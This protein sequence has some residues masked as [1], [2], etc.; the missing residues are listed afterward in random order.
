MQTLISDKAFALLSVIAL[1]TA[2]A[3]HVG[4]EPQPTY[5]T[6]DLPVM[7]SSERMELTE[8]TVADV[9]VRLNKRGHGLVVDGRYGTNTND[10]LEMEIAKC[11]NSHMK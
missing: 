7:H 10:A 4:C 11:S 5:Q 6:Y 2:I 9:Q 3:L 8:G 1:I